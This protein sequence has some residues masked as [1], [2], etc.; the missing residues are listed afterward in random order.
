VSLRTKTNSLTAVVFIN[1]AAVQGVAVVHRTKLP[2]GM[3][4]PRL[5][6]LVKLLAFAHAIAPVEVNGR[7]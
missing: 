4:S 6:G 3:P 5:V 7:T 1:C 2:S